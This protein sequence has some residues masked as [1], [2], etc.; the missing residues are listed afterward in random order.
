MPKVSQ[1]YL[2]TVFSIVRSGHRIT[3]QITQVLKEDGVSEPQYNVLRNL[4][5]K[6][7]TPQTVQDIQCAMVQ[8][9]SNVTRIIDKLLAKG[10]VTRTI[11]PSNRRKMDI[12]ITDKGIDFLKQLDKKVYA[13]HETMAEKLSEEELM[14]LHR[15]IRKLVQV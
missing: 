10:L 5:H 13:F 8:R 12:Q 1:T 3:D 11:C 4:A 7:E 6:P 2:R 14:T 9:T 15:L